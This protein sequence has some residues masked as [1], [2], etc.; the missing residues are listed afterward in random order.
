MGCV[1]REILAA[2]AADEG[3]LW[4]TRVLVAFGFNTHWNSCGD[5]K[6]HT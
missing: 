5:T 6:L 2:P 4:L 3:I 1:V